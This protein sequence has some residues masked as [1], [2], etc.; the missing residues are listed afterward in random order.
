M[1][2]RRRA[3]LF[4]ALGLGPLALLG[5]PRVAAAALTVEGAPLVPLRGS[6]P[7]TV[8]MHPDYDLRGAL[9][10]LPGALDEGPVVRLAIERV[11]APGGATIRVFV[12][13][14]T[15]TADTPTSD[16]HYVGSMTSFEDPAAGSPGDDFLLDAGRAFK[17]LKKGDRLLLGDNVSVTLV[18]EPGSA[19]ADVAIPVERVVLSVET[20]PGR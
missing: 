17:R 19:G 20:A 16:F 9:R 3:P 8:V 5:L 4:L 1:L 12:N 18:L 11:K 6:A 15:A 10:K 7:V 13:L 2:A 14:P